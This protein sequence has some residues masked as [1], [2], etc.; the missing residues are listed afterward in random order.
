M[1]VATVVT[2]QDV[3]AWDAELTALTDGL[4]WLF[5]RPEPKVTF[6]LLVR[7]MLSDA[8]KKNCWG[9]AEHAG[10]P[11]PKRFQL[12]LRDGS[13]DADV[14]RDW[15]RGYAASG[16]ADADAALV[17]DDTQAIKKGIK[18][19][20]VARQ[21]CGLTGQIENCQVMVMLSYASAHGHAF[22]DR[23]LYL[24]KAWVGDVDR[25]REAG[26]PAGRQARTKPQLA[27]DMLGR[28]LADEQV[29][30][31]WVVADAGY[32]RDP[33][34]RGFCH[35][36]VL[37]YVLAVP[38][39]LPLCGAR[40]EATRP[41]VLLADTPPDAW[42]QRSCGHGSKGQRYWDFA[43]HAVTV[44]GQHPAPGFAHTLLIRRA[45][46]AK[47]T[48]DHPEGIHEVAYFLVH[49]PAG[50]PVPAMIT[51]AGL[52]WNIEDDNR[53]GKDQLGLDQYQVRKW[54]PWHRHVTTSML[55]HAFLAV[56]R[57]GLGKD[58]TEPADPTAPPPKRPTR[59]P[60]PAPRDAS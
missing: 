20:G 7:A 41:D 23:E 44:K 3:E 1:A 43:A 47:V 4:G 10:L 14:L 55:A 38:V 42:Q 45:L 35:D 16:L 48:K 21:H 26:V 36:H 11:N 34:L 15:V 8:G 57:A 19:V 12:L 31:R 54:N 53:C 28:A 58:P 49:A 2:A 46:T 56:T 27:V 52:R 29:T 5:A 32:G 18:S 30:F 40:G 60:P 39:D 17:M 33:G 9:M 50:T 25:C 22:V 51:A 13:W 59:T 37:S 6:G 24:P